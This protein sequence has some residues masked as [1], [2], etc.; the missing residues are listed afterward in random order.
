VR[1]R[2]SLAQRI[3]LLATAIAVITAVL[4]GSIAVNLI[5]KA[6]TANASKTLAQLADAAQDTAE[7]G[8]SAAA[9]QTRARRTLAALKIQFLSIS[10]AGTIQVGSAPLARAS[11]T[12]TDVD[13]LLGGSRISATRTVNGQRVLLE[14]RR[15]PAGA[16]VLVQRRADATALGDQLIRRVLLALLVGVAISISLGLIVAYRIARPLHRTAAAAHA[17][18]AGHRDVRVVAEGPTEVAAVGEA[19]NSLASALLHSEARQR[20]FLLSISHELRTPL[21][22][23]SGYAESLADGVI[24]SEQAAEVGTIMLTE[25]HRLDRLVADLLDLARLDAQEFRIDLVAVDLVELAQAAARV[26]SARCAAAGVRFALEVP[27]VPAAPA[28]PLWCHTDPSRLRQLLDGLFDNALRV[29]PSGRPIVLA[30][31]AESAAASGPVAGAVR[32]VAEVRDGGPG[33]TDD[34]LAI[35]F[36]RSALYERYRGVRQVGTGLGLAIVAGLAQ[37]LG[38]TVEAGHAVEGGARFT[39]RLPAIS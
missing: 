26:W 9:G 36:Q 29:T 6:N 19:L 28:S 2:G 11:V 5:R 1:H 30:V 10:S 24:P 20:D 7:S 3:S 21:T 25:A 35:A 14:G 13:R 17:L 37:R 15:T 33:L 38:G 32:V 16:I 22:A 4:A 31:R 8:A 39:V 12:S 23:I 34:D 27:E 18:A